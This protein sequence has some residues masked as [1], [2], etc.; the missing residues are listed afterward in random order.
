MEK[1][2][3]KKRVTKKAKEVAEPA[4]EK[5]EVTEVAPVETPKKTRK[6][7]AKKAE[8]PAEEVVQTQAVLDDEKTETLAKQAWEEYKAEQEKPKTARKP[9]AKKTEKKE[10]VKEEKT[11]EKPVVEKHEL[12]RQEKKD[13]VKAIV[14]ELLGKEKLRRTKLIDEASKLYVERYPSDE[15][16][17]VNDVKGRVGSVIT[18]MEHAKEIFADGNELT[19]EE[20]PQKHLTIREEKAEEPIP[21]PVQEEFLPVPAPE[22]KLAPVF[23]MSALLGEK[24]KAIK[25]PKKEEKTEEK[26]AKATAEEK[27]KTAKPKAEKP[28]K[29]RTEKAKPQDKLKDKFLKKIR[30]HGGSYLEYY[31]VYLL[32]RY[33]QANG[34]RLEMLRV[35]GGEHDGGIDGEIELTDIFGFRE[36]LYI[37]AK[38][39]AP[40]DEKWMVGET[41]LQQFIGAVTYR[42][43]QSGKNNC[44]GVYV[45]TS[46]FS[47]GAKKILDELSEKFVGYDGNDLFDLAKECEFGLIKKDGEWKL[48]ENLLAG[49]KAF[50]NM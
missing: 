34:R 7:R 38:N 31:A 12:T 8:K 25:E 1:E 46:V 44:R 10:P 6:P 32:Q 39:W 37:Q 43:A 27:K 30:D 50:F 40:T 41:L 17:N 5:Q 22:S 26:P 14:K 16:A 19:L 4:V 33:A 21:A 45:T 3:K 29:A 15:T 2:V 28:V 11:E 36:T 9:R 23:D 20:P 42:Q 24:T 35:C 48:D 13:A 18:L 47:E 49:E